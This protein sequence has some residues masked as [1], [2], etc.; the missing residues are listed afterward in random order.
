MAAV[1]AADVQVAL[2]EDAASAAAALAEAVPAAAA[3]DAVSDDR[4]MGAGGR[5]ILPPA[6][7]CG[8]APWLES[9]PEFVYN[10]F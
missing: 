1:S 6:N 8:C 5:M 4:M 7:F 2:E 3:A 9:H 10:I